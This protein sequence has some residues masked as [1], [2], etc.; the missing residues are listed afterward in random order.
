MSDHAVFASTGR[1]HNQRKINVARINKTTGSYIWAGHVVPPFWTRENDHNGLSVADCLKAV[2]VPG[3]SDAVLML[4]RPSNAGSVSNPTM[5]NGAVT[6]VGNC[7]HAQWW[8][9]FGQAHGTKNVL[10]LAVDSSQRPIIATDYLLSSPYGE[11]NG[12]RIPGANFAGM[13]Y[14]LTSAGMLDVSGPSGSPLTLPSGVTNYF[15]FLTP[16][17]VPSASYV[18]YYSSLRTPNAVAS[19]A[20]IRWTAVMNLHDSDVFHRLCTT[21]AGHLVSHGYY[22]TATGSGVGAY[23]NYLY[24]IT[25][26]TGCGAS[27]VDPNDMSLWAGPD[28]AIAAATAFDTASPSLYWRASVACSTG[29]I[30]YAYTINAS[31]GYTATPC[32]TAFD[33]SFNVLWQVPMFGETTIGAT[34]MACDAT[35][36]YVSGNDLA[37]SGSSKSYGLLKLSPSGDVLW[38]QSWGGSSGNQDSVRSLAVSDDGLCLWAG[39]VET[40]L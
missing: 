36:V 4:G 26:R 15:N 37:N 7:D 23:L 3:T 31:T 29:S 33:L 21:D 38:R 2:P 8:Y 34:R 14:R 18:D 6:R 32:V 16:E 19:S 12:P 20:R 9:H 17:E 1:R 39:G 27:G 25:R 11:V 30:I 13:A 24:G 5:C 10:D 22:T 35:G 28:S 40:T